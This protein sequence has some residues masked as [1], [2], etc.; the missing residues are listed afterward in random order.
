MLAQVNACLHTEEGVSRISQ[1]SNSPHESDTHQRI[2]EAA[3]EEFVRKGYKGSI[4]R[5]IAERADVNEVTLFRHFGSKLELLRAA[6]EHGLRK[7]PLPK[8][9]DE[10][11]ALPLREGLHRI[12]VE[13]LLQ[14]STQRDIFMLGIEESFSHPEVID[15]LRLYMLELWRLFNA[16]FDL[17]VARGNL[18][19]ADYRVVTH[20]LISA[21]KFAPIVRE[22]APYDA[23]AQ[24]T[25]DALIAGTVET[26]VAAYGLGGDETAAVVKGGE[27]L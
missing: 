9:L 8:S 18:R 26:I 12:I 22:R 21:F 7:M 23:D 6:V 13:Y 15:S 2:L 1:R 17:L 5:A 19:E 3:L 16:Y 14:F 25:D 24:I 11:A 27:N 10:Y 4:T 20:M